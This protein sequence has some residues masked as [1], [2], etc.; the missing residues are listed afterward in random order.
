MARRRWIVGLVLVAS[1]GAVAW[2][3]RPPADSAPPEP[4]AQARPEPP[5]QRPALQRLA[6][7]ALELE[8]PAE[9]SSEEPGRREE[10]PRL[11]EMFG[12]ASLEGW[13]TCP[14]DLPAAQL[15]V[16]VFRVDGVEGELMGALADGVLAVP[17]PVPEG[18]GEVLFPGGDRLALA[19]E[20]G[21][22][23]PVCLGGRLGLADPEQVLVKGVV[24]NTEGNPEPDTFVAGCGVQARP[25]GEGRFEVRVAPEAC[26]LVA[27][28]R[29]GVLNS[30]SAPAEVD[31]RPGGVLELTLTLPAYP[32]GGMGIQFGMVAHGAIVHSVIP[33]SAA[34]QAGLAPGDVIVSV[35]GEPVAGLSTDE[36]VQRGTGEAGTDVEVEVTHPDGGTSVHVLRRDVLGG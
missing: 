30:V 31:G 4:V 32:K 5:R 28:R 3:I 2:W 26:T 1:V 35:Q 8:A 22:A 6:P 17:T 7:G 27:G 12:A 36:F 20:Q 19:W 14:T 21:P 23:G 29:D 10:L 16:V 11:A 25:D 34:D 24:L 33:G 9:A 13:L 15:E 18:E